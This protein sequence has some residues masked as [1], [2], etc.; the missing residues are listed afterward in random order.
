[1]S[2]TAIFDTV[3]HLDYVLKNSTFQEMEFFWRQVKMG[4]LDRANLQDW[5][6]GWSDDGP[7]MEI[8]SV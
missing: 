3:H 6:I 2:S 8:S 4:P 5:T 7:V 1:M